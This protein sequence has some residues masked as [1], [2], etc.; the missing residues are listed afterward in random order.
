MRKLIAA[1][2]AAA[3]I[4]V[5]AAAVLQTS[6]SAATTT[7]LPPGSPA[8]QCHQRRDQPGDHHPGQPGCHQHGQPAKP[9]RRFP[10]HHH[11]LL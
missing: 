11:D 5:G 8:R 9:S 1:L 3:V 7:F 4:A 6:A 10:D 2:P